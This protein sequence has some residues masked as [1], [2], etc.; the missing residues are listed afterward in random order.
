ME[1]NIDFGNAIEKL[2]EMMSSNEG[3]GQIENIIS[4][5]TGSDENKTTNTNQP[6]ADTLKMVMRAQELMA[7][8]KKEQNSDEVIFLKSL[9][10]FLK[11]ERQN[12]IDNAVKIMSLRRVLGAFK[13]GKQ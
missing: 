9:R 5:F 13:E 2:Q 7:E 3:R 10:P 11:A 6:D 4:A 1:D 12:G 8:F